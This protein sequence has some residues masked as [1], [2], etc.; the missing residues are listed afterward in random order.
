MHGLNEQDSKAEAPLISQKGKRVKDLIK[1]KIFTL[2]LESNGISQKQIHHSFRI[3]PVDLSL[4]IKELEADG[5][6]LRSSVQEK[7]VRG[8]PEVFFVADSRRIVS[9]ALYVESWNIHGVVLDMHGNDIYGCRQAI[10]GDASPETLFRAQLDL[11]SQLRSA[12]PKTS[13][14]AGIGISLPGNVDTRHCI[15]R[16]CQRWPS[17]RDMDYADFGRET[18]LPVDIYRDLDAQLMFE[19]ENNPVLRDEL[20]VLLHWGIGLGISFAC[21]GQIIQSNHGRF[22]T[23]GF[24]YSSI[25]ESQNNNGIDY[26]CITSLRALIQPLRAKYPGLPLDETAV[27]EIAKE[28]SFL[29]LSAFSKAVDYVALALRNLCTVFYP[30]CILLMSPFAVNRHI[31]ARLVEAFHSLKLMDDNRIQIPIL[32]IGN[33]YSGCAT[34]S[35]KQLFEK[36]LQKYLAVQY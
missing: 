6:I 4:A 3:R 17:V 28:D 2:I 7:R 19:K 13:E 9:F 21:R 8:R 5:L 26:E 16:E 20:V 29:D 18:A 34:G 25:D 27:A 12:T 23:L 35:T 32:P 30:D 15:W 33:G 14:I 1:E 10:A 31:V 22:G 11:V 24:M 36:C